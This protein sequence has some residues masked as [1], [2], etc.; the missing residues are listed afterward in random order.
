[1][2]VVAL[3][4]LKGGVGKTSSAVNLAAIA[5]REG[6]RTLLWDLDA[7]GGSSYILRRPPVKGGLKRILRCEAPLAGLVQ[8]TL[9]DRLSL[10]PASTANRKLDSL[11]ERL[12]AR[13]KLLGRLIEPLAATHDVLL[14]DCPPSLS[15]LAE[16]VLRA[17]HL[18]VTP[19]IPAPLSANAFDVLTAHLTRHG[20]SP[21]KV[22]PVFN[23]V[24]RRRRLHREW[25]LRPPELLR[26]HFETVIPAASVVE[27]M[28]LRREPLAAFA[29]ASAAG[30][31]YQHLW[32]E[33]FE[34]LQERP[35]A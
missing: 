20:I 17:A 32:H 2:H 4:N 23:L 3:F 21:R 5:A 26:R 9:Y 6:F 31:A 19:V 12:E 1:M 8:E 15:S 22:R 27:Q 25:V 16:Q 14:L 33:I 35:P 13:S 30:L 11:L 28:S 18:V 24:D 10:L 7:Q 29:P 34:W